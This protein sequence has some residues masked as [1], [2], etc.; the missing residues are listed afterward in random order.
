[1]IEF[2][3]VTMCLGELDQGCDGN[4]ACM[5]F[6]SEGLSG[7]SDLLIVVVV[8]RDQPPKGRDGGPHK[9]WI[10]DLSCSE[11]QRCTRISLVV[12]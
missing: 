3:A 2:G 7:E 1:M 9:E 4:A 12:E 10:S 11:S 8:E 6:T 5:N